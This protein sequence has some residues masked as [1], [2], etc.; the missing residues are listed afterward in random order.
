VFGQIETDGR[1]SVTDVGEGIHSG[2]DAVLS[3]DQVDAAED[4]DCL[5]R[6]RLARLAPGGML[7]AGS[8]LPQ[9]VTRMREWCAKFGYHLVTGGPPD[10]AAPCLIGKAGP[11][12][13]PQASSAV[14]TGAATGVVGSTGYGWSVRGTSRDGY[15]TRVH[16][17]RSSFSVGPAVS[18]R[19]DDALPCAIEALLGALAADIAS[20]LASCA[21][22]RGV[23]IDAVECRISA[24]LDDPLSAIGVVG[25]SGSPALRA[26]TGVVYVS[27]DVDG[28]VLD[29]VWCG[30]LRRSPLFNT[31]APRVA[32]R[33][34]LRP[35]P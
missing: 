23:E 1:N 5:L 34:E 11:R 16:A 9:T 19:P 4:V 24:E 17:G 27:A 14:T 29:G 15:L 32:L 7:E 13:E 6:D 10:A 31:L 35:E 30:A 12:A 25:A 3:P 33:M 21:R 18:F 2:I 26:V 28:P 22:E 20:S 8:R